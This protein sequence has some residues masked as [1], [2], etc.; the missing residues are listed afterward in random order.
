MKRTVILALLAALLLPAATAAKGGKR[1][2]RSN[3][4]VGTITSFDSATNELVITTNGGR[5][6]SALVTQATKIR[7]PAMPL[8]L[9]N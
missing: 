5:A 8:V 1:Q 3:G 7:C 2:H 6:L 9:L 4:T